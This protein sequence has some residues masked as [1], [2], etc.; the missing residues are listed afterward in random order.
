MV[1]RNSAADIAAGRFAQRRMRMTCA[2]RRSRQAG[3]TTLGI[4][5]IG[6]LVGLFAFAGLRLSP[7]YLNYL[8]VAG[9]LNGVQDEFEGQNPSRA[10]IR[11]SIQRRFD[12]ESV[13]VIRS[14]DI[15]VSPDSAGFV[16]A[17]VYDHTSPFIGNISFTVHFD[18]QVLVRR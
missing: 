16:V 5:F 17:A 9:V 6:I 18:K 13:S 3:M 2:G 12:V 1:C 14:S 11:R 4:L 15:K 8:K 7:I 10:I